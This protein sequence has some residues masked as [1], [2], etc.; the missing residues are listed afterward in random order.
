[1]ADLLFAVNKRRRTDGGFSGAD[2]ILAEVEQGSVSKSIAFTVEGRQPVREGGRILDAEGKE[3]GRVTSGGFSP[4]LEAPIGMGYVAATLAE[5]F[6]S[7]ADRHR[8]R[9]TRVRPLVSLLT[10]YHFGGYHHEHHLS[11]GTPWWGLPSVRRRRA[12]PSA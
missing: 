8:A 6:E 9:S 2:R 3:V 4:S 10:C 11:P 5:T 1:M 12:E 7:F